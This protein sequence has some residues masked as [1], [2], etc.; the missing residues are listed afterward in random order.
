MLPREALRTVAEPRYRLFEGLAARDREI[1]LATAT[2]RQIPPYSVITA[3]GNAADHLY[4]LASGCVR[5]FCRKYYS[6]HD[7][8]ID[9]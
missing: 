6:L 7:E 4:L 1:V 9:E 8:Q 2:T 5:L 3:Q